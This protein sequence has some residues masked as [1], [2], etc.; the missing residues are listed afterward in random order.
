MLVC[1][2]ACGP[3]AM[4]TS[5]QEEERE[6]CERV[7]EARVELRWRGAGAVALRGDL[8]LEM[9]LTLGMLYERRRA[10]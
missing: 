10:R 4:K 2:V 7:G 9:T 6:R 3:K 8:L 1:S 5:A